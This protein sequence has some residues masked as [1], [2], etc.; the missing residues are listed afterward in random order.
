[1]LNGRS[2]VSMSTVAAAPFVLAW[3]AAPLRR[4][5]LV[6]VGMV[7][8]PSGAGGSLAGPPV[9]LFTPLLTASVMLA[10]RDKSWLKLLDPGPPDQGGPSRPPNLPAVPAVP[11]R[12]SRLPRTCRLAPGQ[13]AER[14]R[15][16]PLGLSEPHGAVV[17]HA[18]ADA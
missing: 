18:R 6:A 14:P 9:G 3:D 11:R 10:S 16:A 15:S 7:L 2:L 13:R 8:T 1:M 12:R 4:G 17:Q 5:A